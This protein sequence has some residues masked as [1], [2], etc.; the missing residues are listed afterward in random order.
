M[1]PG[2]NAIVPPIPN[3]DA[4]NVFLLRSM[5]DTRR[6]HDYLARR[7]PRRAVIVGAGFI[8][9]E[10]AEAMHDRAI[11]VTLVEK[12]PQ[13]LPPLDPEMA[14]FVETE[15][16]AQ[17]VGVITGIGLASLSRGPGQDVTQAQLEDG[18]VIETDMVLL[19]IGVRPS[20]ELA[21]QAGLA[22]GPSGGILVD[23]YQRTSDLDIYAV[24]DA[25]EVIHGVTQQ[26]A[27][28]P[29]A[30]PANRQ[31]RRAGEHAATGACATAANPLGT[32]IV[33]VFALSVAMTG[34]SERSAKAAG[35]QADCAYVFPA[36]H[37]TYYPGAHRLHLKLVYDKP[38]GKVLGAQVIGAAGV[39]KR[40]DVI[41]TAL[42]FGATVES[43][44]SI[45]LAY[46]PQFS[47]AKDPVHMAAM[48]AQNQRAGITRAISPPELDG[49]VLLDVR[50]RDEFSRGTLPRTINIPVDELRS[51]IG[52]LDATRPTVVFCQLGMRGYVAQRILAQHGFADVKNLKGGYLLALQF[53]HK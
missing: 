13:V 28:I 33:Q 31:G 23:G 53:P 36:H 39:D 6:V 45:D 27:H 50:S 10:V 4:P 38:T 48:V 41:A 44:A 32:A 1:R 8:G 11:G 30:G 20:T 52:E 5:E 12:M 24:G 14:T 26:P 25:S 18:R 49:E 17:G 16:E 15:L 46:A 22:I 2:A 42:H 35:F 7:S 3:V 43:L 40:I 9:L 47:S 29:L 34:L 19:S 21:Q 51:R 37:A